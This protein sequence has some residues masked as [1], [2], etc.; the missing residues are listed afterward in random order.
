MKLI[1]QI[2]GTNYTESGKIDIAR[3]F[4][5]LVIGYLISGLIGIGYGLLSD[6]NPWI[7]LNFILLGITGIVVVFAASLFRMAGKLRNRY[8]AM[9]LAAFFGFV[10][11]YNAWSAIYA[12]GDES[13]FGGL[14][15]QHSLSELTRQVSER[16]LSIG[17][18]GRDGAG[19]GT[20]MTSIIYI[21]EFLILTIVPAWY[22]VKDPTYY[23]EDCDKPMNETEYFFGLTEEQSKSMEP[24]VKSGKLKELFELKSYEEKK[25]DLSLK[26]I[27]CTSN[28]CPECGTL[29][30]SADLGGAKMEKEDTTFKKQESWVKNVFGTRS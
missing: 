28:E 17:K 21:I 14:Y 11:I 5:F 7:Y 18:F 2:P 13:V 15:F 25:L 12:A 4:L 24:G 22:I 9:L 6:L 23:C 26:Y 8:V 20:T 29:V 19:L 3:F 16:V 1:N 27:Q 30:Y 10:C